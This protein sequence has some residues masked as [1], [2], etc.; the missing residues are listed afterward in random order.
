[1]ESLARA[2][3]PYIGQVIQHTDRGEHADAQDFS[4]NL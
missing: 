3:V 2:A 1:M 4:K